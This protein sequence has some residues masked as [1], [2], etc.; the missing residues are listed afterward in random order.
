[1]SLHRCVSRFEPDAMPVSSKVVYCT[2]L[3]SLGH[4]K[5]LLRAGGHHFQQ[6]CMAAHGEVKTWARTSDA[7]GLF[8]HE[9][10]VCAPFRDPLGGFPSAPSV[11]YDS[12]NGDSSGLYPREA[13]WVSTRVKQ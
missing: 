5:T 2:G 9:H 13:G 8:S 7:S 10:A 11:E 3:S 4:I 6:C 1:M 12:S